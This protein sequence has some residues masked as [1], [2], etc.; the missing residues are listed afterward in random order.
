MPLLS[1][2]SA[3][4]GVDV[5]LICL[6]T[7]AFILIYE[8]LDRP[9][10]RR[11]WA[12]AGWLFGSALGVKYLGGYALAAAGL[13]LLAAGQARALRSFAFI[14]VPAAILIPAAWW[15][16]N[17]LFT[18][19]PAYPYLF[20]HL[21][22]EDET[23]RLHL[24]YAAE[25]RRSHHWLDA[26]AGLFP[27][28][29]TRGTYAGAAEALAPFVFMIPALA[30]AGLKPF[31]P[32][33]RWLIALTALLYAGW[34]AAGGG[35]FRFLAPLFPASA[36]AAG[37]LLIRIPG[38]SGRAVTCFLGLSLLVQL[39]LL[40]AVHRRQSDPAGLMLGCET[41]RQY[42][43]RVIPPH[44]RFLP[45][46]AKA[47]AVA[48]GGKLYV[49]GD[50]MA[51]YSPGRTLTEF[52]F[53]P[54]LLMALAGESPEAWRMRVRLK[55]RNVTAILYRPDGMISIGKMSGAKLSGAALRRYAGFWRDWMAP[56]WIEESASERYF[57]QCYSLRRFPGPF[58]P[59]PSGLWYLLPGTEY[60][61]QDIDL[62]LDAG[63]TASALKM[64]GSLTA[65]EPGYG[66][67][68]Y[69]LWAAARRLGDLATARKAAGMVRS[70][71]FGRLLKE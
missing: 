15:I 6:E 24:L 66:P 30:A 16:K 37:L 52:E 53:A 58:V 1:S 44:G 43:T 45:A 38:L 54:P 14:T 49:L 2:Q 28:C 27:V 8:S 42:L 69:R 60:L 48:R 13:A 61:T 29:L 7:A 17:W 47:G 63:R 65:R 64:A 62:A 71:G 56:E 35:I 36:M 11:P 9:A 3:F 67:G 21:G 22:I 23:M 40:V 25:W 33:K 41:E 32:P 5:M 70:L 18:G 20:G 39:P 31:S 50:P 46:L 57:L 51:F 19:N 34:C 4:A 10:G 12:A 26:W 59:P 55:Q 68:W